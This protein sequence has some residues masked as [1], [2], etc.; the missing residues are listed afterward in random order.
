MGTECPGRGEYRRDATG[1]R[2]PGHR[3]SVFGAA[4]DGTRRYIAGPSRPNSKTVGP[5]GPCGC[6][7][8]HQ[9]LGYELRS[10][11]CCGCTPA[12]PR[13]RRRSAHPVPQALPCARGPLPG[14]TPPAF[15]RWR[16]FGVKPVTTERNKAGQTGRETLSLRTL[17]YG[18]RRA[19]TRRDV[20]CR[21]PGSLIHASADTRVLD[22]LRSLL[23]IDLTNRRFDVL[24]SPPRPTRTRGVTIIRWSAPSSPRSGPLARTF[25]AARRRVRRRGSRSDAPSPASSGPGSAGG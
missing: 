22:H 1:H 8:H 20:Q 11:C 4:L 14:P 18:R 15:G 9:R 25:D 13:A 6:G 17:R 10:Q 5:S 3:D 12:L 16:Q 23:N 19:G 7:S 2:P 24:I 21:S